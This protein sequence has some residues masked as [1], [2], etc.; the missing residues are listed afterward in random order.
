LDRDDII[1]PIGYY[2]IANAIAHSD[3]LKLTA[4][5]NALE[6][7]LINNIIKKYEKT[8]LIEDITKTACKS[9]NNYTTGQLLKANT[10]II[11]NCIKMINTN[12]NLGY[13][14]EEPNIVDFTIDLRDF[15]IEDDDCEESDMYITL[16]YRVTVDNI[17][18]KS[19]GQQN[20]SY[21]KYRN[22]YSKAKTDYLK[23][24]HFK[25]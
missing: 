13:K 17:E 25:H 24:T 5:A 21:N 9:G 16:A 8:K 15:D 3:V 19:T 7:E 22:M 18:F 10:I 23:L 12:N 1:K 2:I 20:G 11:L 14:I 6:T 4:A